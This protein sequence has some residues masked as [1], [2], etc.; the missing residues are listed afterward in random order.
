MRFPLYPALLLALATPLTAQVGFPP[1]HSP[2]RPIE[3]S[4]FFEFDGGH[5]G[6]TG[7]PIRVGPRD[8]TSES[9]RMEFRSNHALQISLGFS[10]AG[11]ERT[12]IDADDSIATRDKGLFKQR[13]LAGEIGFQL[14]LTGGKSWHGVAPYAGLTFGLVHGS[15]PP[16]IDTSGYSFGNKLF[17]APNLGTRFFVTQRLYLNANVRAWVWKLSYP[18]SYRDEPAKQPGTATQSNAVITNGKT[19]QYTFTPEL[20]I[21]IGISP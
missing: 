21:G 4:T 12:V 14:N 1:A 10:T 5:V 18:P 3:R 17:F 6:G 9:A 11:T 13:I 7:G 16:A 8:G 2:Y 20:R 19:S 15:K